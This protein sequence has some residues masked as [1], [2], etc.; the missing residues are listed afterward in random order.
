MGFIICEG[1]DRTGKSTIAEIFRKKGYKVIHLLAPDKKYFEEG[2]AGPSYVDELLEFYMQ[3]DGQNIFFD[4]SA[5]GELVWPFIHGRDPKISEEDIEVLREFEE[6]NNTEYILMYDENIDANWKRCVDDKEPLSR[7]KFN[8]AIRLYD[9]LVNKYGF[10]KKQLRD[11]LGDDM[12]NKDE[13]KIN[14]N[15]NVGTKIK[16]SENKNNSI[17]K[18]NEQIKLEKANAINSILSS[19]I[20]KRKGDTY[21]SI[22]K[23]IREFLNEKLR[24]IFGKKEFTD[25]F[26]DEELQ[27]LKI[28]CQ[29]S[30]SSVKNGG[31]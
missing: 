6:R 4:R 1:V 9:R 7:N 5:Y 2:Y 3:Y 20:I 18:T 14:K 16:L 12:T 25:N 11:F 10:K 17:A 30:L 31:K 29:R 22:E 24:S 21:D 23:D 15:K 26:S 28:F 8:Q 19:R 13:I 27:V